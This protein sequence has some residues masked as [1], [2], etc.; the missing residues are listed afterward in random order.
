MTQELDSKCSK[1][2]RAGDKLFLKGD[3]C[4]GPKC[5]LLKRNFPP[6][7]HG[8]TTKKHAKPSSYGRQLAEK[9]EAK[10]HYGLRERQ[11]A[12]YVAEASLKTGDT[13]KFLINYL[14]ARLDNVIYRMGFAPSRSM[15]RQIVSHGHVTVNGKKLDIASYRVKVGDEIAL[16]AKAKT[17]KAFEKLAE[18]L[19]KYEAPSWLHVDAS[20]FA[21][22]V[23]NTPSVEVVPFNP[24]AIIEF[25]S[26]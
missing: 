22:K 24:K 2:R 11:F 3:K 20:K 6:G 5:P 14:E 19:A 12:N 18:K 16:S 15:A 26:R 23:L 17:K 21:A 4:L 25:Y 13:S 7:Q 8:P 1:C 9:Q 10:R